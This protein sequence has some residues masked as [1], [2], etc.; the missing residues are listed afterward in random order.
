MAGSKRGGKG[1]SL[2]LVAVL[3]GLLPSLLACGRPTPTPSPTPVITFACLDDDLG[4]YEDLAQA[5]HAQHPDLTVKVAARRAA[6]LATMA[7][8]EADAF[9]VSLPLAPLLARGALLSLNSLLSATSPSLPADLYP[10]ARNAFTRDGQL[11]ALPVGVD[12]VVMFYNKTLF[13]T[14]GVPFPA[15]NWT[16]DDFRRTAQELRDAQAGV[17]G[18]AAALWRQEPWLFILQHGGRLVDDWQHPTRIVLDDPRT[19]E[20][21]EWYA[22]MIFRL[23][24]APTPQEARQVFGGEQGAYSGILAGKVAMWAGYLSSRTLQSAGAS[25]QWGV[26]PLPRDQ[27]AA[28]L[29]NVEAVAISPQTQHLQATWEWVRFLSDQVPRRLAPGRRSVAASSAFEERVGKET[30]ATVRAA[31]EHALVVPQEPAAVYRQLDSA[32]GQALD[33]ILAARFS[34]SEALKQAQQRAK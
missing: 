9:V 27:Q 20:A 26:A 13:S 11:W 28:T 25:F 18:Y 32:W 6:A 24:V 34:P 22:A 8:S 19:M 7:P 30:A 14:R 12:P 10:C 31:L 21:M 16:W 23:D 2:T 15:D 4:Y 5:F 17:Y 29:A 33:D 1:G 3:L